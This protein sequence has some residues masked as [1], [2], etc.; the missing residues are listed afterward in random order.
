MRRCLCVFVCRRNASL[1]KGLR[2]S[3]YT[4][5]WLFLSVTSCIDP[6]LIG[7]VLTLGKMMMKMIRHPCNLTDHGRQRGVTG[8]ES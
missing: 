4:T 7:R 3:C 1:R 8:S 2:F 6:Y 5:A